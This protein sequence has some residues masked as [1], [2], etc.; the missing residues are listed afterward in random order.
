MPVKFL[1]NYYIIY[2]TVIDVIFI[3]SI[4]K[5]NTILKNV[6]NV[7]KHSTNSKIIVSIGIDKPL[8]KLF[9]YNPI[10]Y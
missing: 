9:G 7:I 1:H 4:S 6:I 10:E 3:L 5:V 2:T 8:F